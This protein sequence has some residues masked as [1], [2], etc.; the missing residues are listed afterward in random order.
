MTDRRTFLA[1]LGT[2]GIVGT[3]PIA[4]VAC[5]AFAQPKRRSIVGAWIV[6]QREKQPMVI[7]YEYGKQPVRYTDEEYMELYLNHVAVYQ[8]YSPLGRLING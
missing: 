7:V 2:L 5:E 6:E 8:P 4:S 1:G 3:L